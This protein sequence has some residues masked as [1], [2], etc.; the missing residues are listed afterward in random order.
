MKAYDFSTDI[1]D[2]LSL[3]DLNE[4]QRY[5]AELVGMDTYKT[6]VSEYNGCTVYIPKLD[7]LA[8]KIRNKKINKEF[9]GKNVAALAKK[10]QLSSV[11]INSI[12]ADKRK[13]LN[14]E[15]KK[16]AESKL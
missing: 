15:K 7:D 5:L 16:H 9:D 2:F 4:E 1:L 13:R 12:V 10:Y 14:K 3:S 11:Q 6:I 8:R